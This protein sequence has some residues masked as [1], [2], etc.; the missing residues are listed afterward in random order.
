MRGTSLS[1]PVPAGPSL[2]PMV[3]RL[4]ESGSIRGWV[5][6]GWAAAYVALGLVEDLPGGEALGLGGWLDGLAHLGATALLASLILVWR[7]AAGD[8]YRAGR[9]WALV[10]SLA[11]GVAIELL[12]TR[13]PGRSFE[14]IDLIADLA[15]AL[16]G[17]AVPTWLGRFRQRDQL[18]VGGGVAAMAAAAVYLL[19]G[20]LA[21]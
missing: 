13:V 9:R 18:F 7:Q 5:A 19:V 20:A 6:L 16:L 8:G 14:W 10:G 11:V 1:S 2:A 3:S 12:Q 15:G 17:I 4:Q 21:G